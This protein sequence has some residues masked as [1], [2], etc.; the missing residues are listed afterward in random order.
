MKIGIYSRR[1]IKKRI[2]EKSLDGYAVVSFYD[3][4]ERGVAQ[5]ERVDYT[6]ACERV[7]Y[8]ALYDLDR[9]ALGEV[10]LDEKSYFPEADALAE[11][12]YRAKEDGLNIICQCEYGQSR[13]A[14][15]AAAI[16]EH[17]SRRGIDIFADYRYY[18]NQLVYHKIMDALG[19]KADSEKDGNF[20][21]K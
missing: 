4:S 3:P 16:L 8:I 2:A 15:C 5:I 17:F 9:E 1:S 14:A 13:S 6:G 11:F 18:P 19:R 10:G 12:I 7:M 21:K 20:G